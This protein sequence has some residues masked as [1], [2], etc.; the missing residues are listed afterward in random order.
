MLK[1]MGWRTCPEWEIRDPHWRVIVYNYNCA[2][3]TPLAGW[4]SEWSV[5]LVDGM[6]ALKAAIETH[7]VEQLEKA[8]S[9]THVAR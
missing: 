7:K 9:R 3:V 6:C 2:Q 8:R 1:A 5:W 4:P